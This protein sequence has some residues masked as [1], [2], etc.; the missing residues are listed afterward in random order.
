MLDSV[1]QQMLG[2]ANSVLRHGL[3]LMEKRLGF[4]FLCLLESICQQMLD[5]ANCIGLRH[6]L[7]IEKRIGF[8][9]GLGRK[10]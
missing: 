4:A 5:R 2:T 10:K 1:F 3:I 9:S 8:A 6:G 7:L